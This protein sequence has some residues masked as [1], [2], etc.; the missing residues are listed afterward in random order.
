MKRNL[1]LFTILFAVLLLVSACGQNPSDQP[2]GTQTSPPPESNPPVDPPAEDP[3]ITKKV[4]LYFSDTDLMDLYK[5]EEELTAE[6]ESD[7][8]LA[9]LESWIKGPE[10][11]QIKGLI[12][13]TTKV[14]SLEIEDSLA[15]VDFSSDL[16]EANV[17][18]TG[19]LFI[20]DQISLILKQ[21][22][23]DQVQILVDGETVDSLF[24]HIKTDKPYELS[25]NSSYQIKT[26][27]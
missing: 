4:E 23:V 21:F 19:E 27:Q 18:S 25:E 9:A 3:K 24:G 12:P 22:G 14:N 26:L 8:P 17:G 11:D 1:K 2:N 13:E 10:S 15:T 5:V 7:L 6:T 20:L 16:K